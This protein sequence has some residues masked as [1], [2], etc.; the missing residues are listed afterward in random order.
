MGR[1]KL[2]DSGAYYD[3]Q[4][5]G[6][7]QTAPPPQA[8]GGMSQSGIPLDSTGRTTENDGWGRDWKNGGRLGEI[9]SAGE[10]RDGGSP[11]G[12]PI[13]VD[14][15]QDGGLTWGQPGDQQRRLGNQQQFMEWLAGMGIKPGQAKDLLAPRPE[16]AQMFGGDPSGKAPPTQGLSPQGAPQPMGQQG[17][18]IMSSM[19][20]RQVPE[21]G[22]GSASSPMTPGLA[23]GGFG[24]LGKAATGLGALGRGLFGR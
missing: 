9:A 23:S 12:G 4:D 20:G 24:S 7:D 10:M 3:S 8:A 18:G 19:F 15:G 1:W 13:S 16:D 14:F 5:S 2:G 17:G 6:P 22:R 11:W 21:A